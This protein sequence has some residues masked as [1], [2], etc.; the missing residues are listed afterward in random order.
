MRLRVER[1]LR[2]GNSSRLGWLGQGAAGSRGEQRARMAGRRAGDEAREAGGRILDRARTCMRG[3]RG[4]QWWVLLLAAMVSVLGHAWS[5]EGCCRGLWGGRERLTWGVAIR[6]G[7]RKDPRPSRHRPTVG[8]DLELPG[9]GCWEERNVD[10]K[11]AGAQEVSWA[12]LCPP[13]KSYVE[14]LTP[15]VM[16]LGDSLTRNQPR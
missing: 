1:H 12:E 7:R 15:S 9:L 6:K 8:N 4:E 13:T 11:T 14:A 16:E 2:C 3:E 5:W 10:G